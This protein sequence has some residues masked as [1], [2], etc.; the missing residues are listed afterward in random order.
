MRY[1]IRIWPG[2]GA[3]FGPASAARKR[4]QTGGGLKRTS[5]EKAAG[6]HAAYNLKF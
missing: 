4:A 6:K 3:P 1:I 5:P 2:H